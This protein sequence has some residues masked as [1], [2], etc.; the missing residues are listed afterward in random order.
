MWP[1][2]A[3][4]D[5]DTLECADRHADEQCPR[6]HAYEVRQ[7]EKGPAANAGTPAAGG[8]GVNSSV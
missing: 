5:V 1:D 2:G 4:D 3:A 6:A 7:F 8:R